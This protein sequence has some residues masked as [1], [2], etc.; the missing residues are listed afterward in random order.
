M[1]P[2]PARST[3]APARRRLVF[4]D[5]AATPGGGQLALLWLLQ[6]SPEIDA[7]VVFLTGGPLLARFHAAGIATTV[8]ADGPFTPRVLLTAL[9]A[10][11]GAVRDARPAAVVATSIAA[12]KA[13]ALVPHRAPKL[14][15]LQEDLDRAR[16]RGLTTQI[17]FRVVHSAFDGFLANSEWTASTIPGELRAVPR[18]V[19]Y[20]PSGID[21]PVA[22]PRGF[23]ADGVLR[24]ATFSRPER[25]KGL[26]LLLDAAEVLSTDPRCP[27]FRIDLFGG[28]AVRDEAY[29]A[30]LRDRVAA[31]PL[32][33]ALHGHV[34]DVAAR[35]AE[36]DVVVVPSRLPEPFGQ[37]VAQAKAAGT[38]VIVTDAGGALE[39]VTDGVDGFVVA[40]GSAAALVE[41]LRVLLHD[42]ALGT[43]IARAASADADRWTDP[44][45]AGA[46]HRALDRVLAQ[47]RCTAGARVLRRG[48][49]LVRPWRSVRGANV[50]AS[51]TGDGR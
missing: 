34:D 31:S 21:G 29:A 46:F 23:A 13:L 28:G 42:P 26:D 3:A 10:L 44:V 22:H 45:L 19:A 8:L 25:W 43:R 49:A 5:H 14:A 51:I 24:V 48:L 17:L 15:Y 18:A 37:V 27:P 32:P 6:N 40:R 30:G 4:V 36:T 38:V 7:H 50:M 47:A 2:S 16:G 35:V 11:A 9:P 12:S 20:P 41:R 39:Q 33:V 1:P